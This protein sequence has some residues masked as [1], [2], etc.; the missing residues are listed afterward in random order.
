[1]SSELHKYIETALEKNENLINAKVINLAEKKKTNNKINQEIKKF[2][3][4]KLYDNSNIKEDGDQL[5]TVIGI[6]F[7]FSVLIITGLYSYLI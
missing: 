3:T 2:E 4:W 6:C 7:M 1:M 5:K